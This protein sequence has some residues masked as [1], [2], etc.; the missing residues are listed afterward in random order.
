MFYQSHT[1]S[2]GI[3]LVHK[4]DDSTVA[5]CGMAINTGTRDEAEHEQGMAHYIEHMLFKG[6]KKR[7]ASHIINRLEDVGG[8]LNAYTNK[9]ETFVYSIILKEDFERAMELTADIVFN[10]I[11]PEQ[12]LKKEVDVILDEIQSYNDSPSDLIFDDF[13]DLVF[14]NSSLGR[15]ILGKAEMLKDYTREDVLRFIANNY[16][17]DE[18]VFFSLGSIDFKKLVR[19]AEKYFGSYPANLRGYQRQAPGAYLPQQIATHKETNQLHLMMGNRAYSLEH[20]DRLGLYLLNNILG[21]PGMNSLLNLALREK[22][23]LAYNVESSCTAYTDT[24]IF[25]IYLGCDPKNKEKSIKLINL[26]LKQLREQKMADARL[27]KY[28]KQLMGQLAISSQNKESLAM[29]IGKSFLRY[30]KIETT[31]EIRA[32]LEAINSEKIQAIANEVFEEKM[33]TSLLFY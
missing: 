16:H 21:G 26:E 18:M 2:N 5:Y 6:T 33:M 4:P 11:F 24:G 22:H 1:L 15:N 9:E 8:E 25:S 20:P 12:E 7:R 28:K 14:A 17:T 31:E 32:R 30:N 19:W 23:G 10:S 3:R 29:S 13:E 27:E